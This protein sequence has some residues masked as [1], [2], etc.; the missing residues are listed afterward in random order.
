MFS[1]WH[2][3]KGK[4]EEARRWDREKEKQTIFGEST[5]LWSGTGRDGQKRGG[6][7]AVSKTKQRTDNMKNKLLE[8]VARENFSREDGKSRTTGSATK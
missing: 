3:R 5:M 1:E 2:L 6:G 8:K 4:K 7:E